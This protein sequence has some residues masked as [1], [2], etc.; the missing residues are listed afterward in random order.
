MAMAVS[1]LGHTALGA[2]GR[3]TSS[4]VLTPDGKTVCA[5]NQD[6]GSV[7]LWNWAGEG[8]VTEIKVGQEPRTLAV[9]PDGRWLYVT[10]QRPQTVSVVEIA[11]GRT[12]AS[13]EVGGQPYGLLLSRDGRQA[14]VSQYAGAYTDGTYAPG[15][16]AVIDLVGRRVV[17]HIATKPRPWAMVIRDDD[18]A[19]YVTH[20]LHVR[21]KGVVTEIDPAAG[22]VRREFVLR[23]DDMAGGQAGVVNGLAGIALHPKGHRALV[24]A[25]HANTRRGRVLNGRP[26]SHKTTVQAAL[27]IIDLERNAEL[28]D[29]RMLSSF[30]GQPVAVPSAVAFVDAEHFIDLYFC[31]NDF[32][33]IKYNEKGYVA[34]RAVRSVPAGPTGVVVAPDGRT[35]FV[36]S[37]WDRSVSQI[38]FDDVRK[39]V[40]VKTV[41]MTAEPW[42]ERRIQGAILFHNTRDTRMTTFRWLS[43]GVCHLDG[44]EVSDG[45]LWDLTPE[46]ASRKVS[47]TM[48]LVLTSGSSPPFFH[49]GEDDA[50]G[51]LERF[52]KVFHR[53]SGFGDSADTSEA[54]RAMLAYMN[55]LTPRPNPHME[56]GRPR[57]EIRDAARRGRTLFFDAQVGCAACHKGPNFA[58]SGAAPNAKRYDVGTGKKLDVPSLLH[59]WDTA[60]YLH[61]GRAETLRE[62][63]TKHNP[64]D[65]HGK[66]SHLTQQQLDDLVA[67]QLAPYEESTK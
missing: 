17:K 22:T 7:S 61:D 60:P 66:T 1:V 16:V 52:V 41:R 19:L 23:E 18:S 63:I 53:G 50:V 24:V 26:L 9:S 15:A 10:N 13:I 67:F 49:R 51:A 28:Y 11:A 64:D 2:A 32:K 8:K 33:V 47:N 5:V 55:T 25:M 39:P 34:E 36:N 21:H 14:F 3:Q 62:V 54:W 44:G 65:R 20:Y 45:V 30:S 29:A 48:D 46:G 40:V 35:A 56:G 58:E 6:S 27:R 57:P 4:V 38:A 59:L 42:H 43:C 37:R 12:C 31:S